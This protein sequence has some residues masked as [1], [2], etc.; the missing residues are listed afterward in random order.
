MKRMINSMKV[1]M[2]AFMMLAVSQAG[3]QEIHQFSIKDAIDYGTKHSAEVKNALLGYKL[4]EQTN[5]AVTSEALPQISGSISS[6]DNVIIATQLLPGEFAGQPAGTFIPIK[7]GTQ[8]NTNLVAT[9]KQ[10]IF[11]GQVF[12][13]LQA[14]KTA[15]AYYQ[16]NA[17]LTEQNIRV[18]IYKVY[19]QLLLSR[20]QVDLIDENIKRAEEL[21]NNTTVLYKNGFSERLDVDKA[22]VQLANLQTEK[23]QTNFNIEN[24]YLGLKILLGMPMRDSLVLKDTLT[25]EMVRDVKLGENLGQY[26][27]RKDYQLLRLNQD[28]NEFDIKR[29][30][31]M[32]IPTVS[33]NGYISQNAFRTQ[34]DI[35]SSKGEWYPSGYVSVNINIPIFDGFY[36]DANIKKAKIS[37]EQT[38]NQMEALKIN[39]DGQVKQAQIRFISAL[40]VLDVQKKNMDLAQSVYEQTRKKYEQGV[41]SNTEITTAESDLKQAQTSYITALYN[42]VIAKIDYQNAIGKI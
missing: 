8:Y 6:I 15:L 5:R 25:Y 20:T 14:R 7:F 27:D 2:P 34:F 39:I 3:A 12:V 30:R 28:L 9:L 18:N 26:A 11:D 33:L 16:K 36:K 24:G 41:G 32:Y 21:L 4:Q 35:F 29:Y 40:S 19:Y 38:Q 13:G 22:T 31:K 23:I 37:L 42:T 10:V 17:E 1:L